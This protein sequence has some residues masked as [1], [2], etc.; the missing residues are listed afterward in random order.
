M[1]SYDH[2]Q[3]LRHN[4]DGLPGSRCTIEDRS[5]VNS[6]NLLEGVFWVQLGMAVLCGGVLGL[7]RQ[8]RGKPA[9][10][11]TSI[12][13]CLGTVMFMRFGDQLSSHN[14]DPART[15]GQIV[16]GIGFLGGGVIFAEGGL[17]KG[18]TSAAVI[19]MLAAIGIAI[20]L[21]HHMQALEL[22]AA[23]T[24]VLVGVQRLEHTFRQLR[25]GV[26]AEDDAP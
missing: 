14:G 11:R 16:N 20:G 6:G 3:L 5:G 18:M 15:L 13:I 17:V 4:L 7:E 21:G 19:W 9:G 23:A 26:H 10:M 2:D 22:T 24:A 25:R 12:L 1:S 8:L